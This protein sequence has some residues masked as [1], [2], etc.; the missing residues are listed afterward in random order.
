[1]KKVLLNLAFCLFAISTWAQNS[2]SG[3]VVDGSSG[4]PLIGASVWT[5]KQGRG[6]VTDENG[7][8]IITKLKEGEIQLRV[9]YV[10]FETLQKS[11]SVPLAGELRLELNPTDLLSEEFIV[12][13]TRASATTP[14]TFQTI[15][16][17]ELAKRNLGQDIPILLNFTPSVVTN[18]DAGAGIGYTSMSIRGSDQSRINVTVNGIP[19]NDAESH[20]VFYVNMPDFASSVDNIQIQRGV[21]T[22]TNGA[23]TF[24]AS[25]NIQTDTRKDEPYAEISNSVGSFNSW[26]HTV[27][28]G[29]GLLNN[30]FAVDARLSKITS[31]GYVD[32]AFSDLK[33]FFVSGGYYGENHV[34]KLNVFSGKEQTY[35]AWW[36]LPESK[37]EEDRTYNYYTYDNETDNYQQDHYQL[38]YTGKIG[39]NWKTNAALHYTYGRGYYEQFREDDDFASYAL[40]NVVIGGETISSTD[41]IRR[42]WLDNDFFGGIASVNYISDDGKW[43]V[44]LG[45]GANRYDGDH[46][47]E[48]IWAR[49][50]GETNIRDRYYDNNAVK[51]DRNIYLKATHEISPGLNLFGDLQL[52]GIDY[53]F[54]GVNDDQRIVDGNQTYT[55]F[56]PKFGL[57]YERSNGQVWY[58]SYAVANREPKRSDFTDN[59]IT[60]I[61]RPERLNDI[62]A[63]VRAQKGKFNYNANFYYMD[64]KDQLILTGQI[65]DVGAYIR[66][67]VANSYRAGIELSG[68]YQISKA[69]TV[70]GN[71]TLSQNKI[72]EFTEYVDDYSTEE[73]QQEAFT[74]EDTDIAF[75]PNAI[76]SAILEYKPIENLSLNWMSKYVGKQFL[77]NS[78]N[79]SRSLDSFFTNDIRISYQVQPRFFKS[80]EVNLMVNNIFNEMYEPNGYTFSYY[81]PG[82][83][84]RELIT[85]NYYYPM[86]GT[87]F[88]LGLTMKF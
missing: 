72:K 70:G 67:N 81:I 49:I 64:Y 73:F 6:A 15:D 22:S 35:Q 75:S 12:S 60:E 41:I 5:E 69:L 17:A 78:A 62:E 28:A 20:G 68:G 37:L 44:I 84:G 86:A 52:R 32:R 48:I 87:N 46:F 1:M 25:L 63:G 29:T 57:S 7:N 55:F 9:S 33:S 66:E 51:D 8:F 80:L 10:G 24:G 4:E 76:A 61:P 2:L 54:Y 82:D 40:P 14:T 59:P 79:D 19:M 71:L 34:V 23:A 56:N 47:G 16:K 21:G 43:D 38:I 11:L 3:K 31:D 65:N 30:R 42:R 39:S 27:K 58:A 77:D 13:A 88:M 83:S 26:K 45:G 18:S 53:T 85:E 50:A 74:Y 36:G